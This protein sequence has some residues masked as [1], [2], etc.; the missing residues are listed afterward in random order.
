MRA[1]DNTFPDFNVGLTRRGMH[2][3]ETNTARQHLWLGDAPSAT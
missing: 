1:I 3:L 2:A